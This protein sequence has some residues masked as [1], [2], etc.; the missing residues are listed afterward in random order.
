MEVEVTDPTHPLF[1]QRFV[2]RSVSHPAGQAGFVYVVY[3]QTMTLRIALAA[4]ERHCYPRSRSRT[5]WT[6]AA[7]ADV[8]ALLTEVQA[9]CPPDPSGSDS[10]RRSA[11]NVSR[12]SP[13]S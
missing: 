6:S 12:P 9:P 10:P 2:V 11:R 8:L 3:Q 1:G 4:T 5:K 7:V 13:R